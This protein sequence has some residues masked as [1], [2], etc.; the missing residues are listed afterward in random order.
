[1]RTGVSWADYF[2]PNAEQWFDRQMQA[3]DEFDTT[4][5]LCFTPE[6]LGVVPH[7]TAPPKRAQDFADFARWAVSRYAPQ[8]EPIRHESLAG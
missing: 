5:T 3:L 2:R 6:H 8:R 1:L 7:Y 4:I